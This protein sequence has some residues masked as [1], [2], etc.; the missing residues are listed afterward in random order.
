ML[1]VNNI[2][3]EFLRQL[4]DSRR[5]QRA[6]VLIMDNLKIEKHGAYYVVTLFDEEVKIHVNKKYIHNDIWR[7]VLLSGVLGIAKKQI[8]EEYR[9]EAELC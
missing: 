1:G 8:K 9:R 2:R 5:D 4:G 3:N 6:K 7:L